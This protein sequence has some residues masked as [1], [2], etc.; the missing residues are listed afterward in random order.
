MEWLKGLNQTMEYIEKNL[1]E[2]IDAEQLGK[3][4]GCSGYHFQRMFSYLANMSLSEYIRRRRMSLAAVDLMEKDAKVIN[5]ALKYGYNSPTAFN[6][7]FQ[8]IHGFA[9]SLVKDHQKTLKAF[10]PMHFSM[11]IS[12]AE[13]LEYRIVK[14]EAFRIVGLCETLS[15]DI[16]QNF[17]E[18]PKFWEKTAMSG[19]IP[20]LLP[21]MNQEPMGLLGASIVKQENEW[22][23]YIAVS[24]TQPKG[25]FEETIIPAYTWA[26]FYKEG[27][28]QDL[29]KLEKRIVTEWFPT[30]G[31][32]YDQGPDLEVYLNTD[33]MNAKFEIWVP[34]TKA[35]K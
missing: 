26:V 11:S 21:L 17:I 31:Y 12:G 32:E 22:S 15:S 16:E 29:Q 3:I 20:M 28:M 7:A 24:S 35:K 5:I 18:V 23:Y 8:S 13:V 19:K 33:P 1:D 4:A 9:P 34:I 10:A 2:E 25:E 6:R 27:T 30:S 14:K